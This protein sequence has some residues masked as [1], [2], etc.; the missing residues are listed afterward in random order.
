MPRIL[1]RLSHYLN[2]HGVSP[3]ALAAAVAPDI[4]RNTIYRLLREEDRLTRL[5]LPTLAV[6]LVTLRRLTGQPTTYADL[7]ELDE[8][9][10]TQPATPRGGE[11]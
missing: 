2:Q 8:D 5:D 6:L 1:L 3:A 4:S 11:G 7:L 9:A 10:P